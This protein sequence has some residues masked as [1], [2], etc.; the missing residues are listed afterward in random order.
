MMK[1]NI[2]KD[3]KNKW[4]EN[5]V[6]RWWLDSYVSNIKK[7][8]IDMIQLLLFIIVNNIL[9]QNNLKKPFPYILY[10]TYKQINYIKLWY[11]W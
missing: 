8:I 9:S 2:Y 11:H 3:K 4:I 10:Y 5:N 1:Q 7:H 6:I